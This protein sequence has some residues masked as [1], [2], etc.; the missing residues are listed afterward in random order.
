MA[1][2]GVLTALSLIMVI[3]L[4]IPLFLDYLI[5]EPGDIPLLIIGFMYGPAYGL[6]STFI[7]AVLMA[8]STGLGGP[9]GAAMH[10]LASGI[11]VGAAAL[12]YRRWH[13][14]RG[15]IAALVVGTI[16][17]TAIM[18]FA[19]WL[20]TPVFYG[21]PRE[22]VT[23]AL[24]PGII[25]FNFVKAAANSIL[26]FLLYKRVANFIRGKGIHNT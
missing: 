6:V 7:V 23:K 15:A 19:N 25:P 2:T 22:V 24:L 8:A 1:V 21:I 3:F 10:F 5:Y 16:L 4:R 18:P 9:F 12:I 14:L 26:T 13:T 17:M 11:L 20:L